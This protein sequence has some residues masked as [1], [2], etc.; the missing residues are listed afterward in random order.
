M[1]T[2]N[3]V[4]QQMGVAYTTVMLWIKQGK[5]EAIKRDHPRGDYYEVP[6]SALRKLDRGRKGRPKKEGANTGND[7]ASQ[8][9]PTAD[10]A[11]G[12]AARAVTA[13]G[14]EAPTKPK[15]TAKKAPGKRT[16]KKTAKRKGTEV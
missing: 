1:L 4:A 8:T 5:L 3:E 2:T 13:T 11:D 7:D 16:A 9:A 14:G 15:A 10:G 12:Q 6:A